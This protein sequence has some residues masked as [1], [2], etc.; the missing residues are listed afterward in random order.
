MVGLENL[1]FGRRRPE[2]PDQTIIV[3]CANCGKKIS[4]SASACPGCG[5]D[6]KR[7]G[8]KASDRISLFSALVNLAGWCV[9]AFGGY[10][11]YQQWKVATEQYRVAYQQFTLAYE[12]FV[13]TEGW[14][15]RAGV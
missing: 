14:K 8:L 10:L 5:A 15:R 11:A 2:G 13:A 3:H 12:Q 7:G 6:L 4:A 9:A 1:G